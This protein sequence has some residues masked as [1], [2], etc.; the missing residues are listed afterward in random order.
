M[1][2]EL[3][4][5]A[6]GFAGQISKYHDRMNSNYIT[7]R[8]NTFW[9]E[10][11]LVPCCRLREMDV[12]SSARLGYN[13]YAWESTVCADVNTHCMISNMCT[14]IIVK[15][16]LYVVFKTH[17]VHM[18]LMYVM[19]IEHLTARVTAINA[20]TVVRGSAAHF[21]R[22]VGW[23][24]WRS[25]RSHMI[26]V[27][28]GHFGFPPPRRVAEIQTHCASLW[29]CRSRWWENPKAQQVA[30]IYQP[31]LPHAFTR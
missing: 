13:L 16:K 7:K 31:E 30:V 15:I 25:E 2:R 8:E 29:I 26:A 11:E 10:F 1:I 23:W 14:H 20:C 3:L 6:V 21:E 27:T 17:F 18:C 9:W 19:F 24:H 22:A 4:R 5:Y 28:R 12:S